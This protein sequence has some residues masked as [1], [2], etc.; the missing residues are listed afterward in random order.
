LT[1]LERRP[2]K[3]WKKTLKRWGEM[4][5]DLKKN[6]ELGDPPKLKKKLE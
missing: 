4:K 5:D 3:K 2:K 1:K 6:M